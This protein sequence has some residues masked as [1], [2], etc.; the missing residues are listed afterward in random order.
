M[1]YGIIFIP[2]FVA[3]ARLAAAAT[4]TKQQ[5]VVVVVLLLLPLFLLVPSLCQL[6]NVIDKL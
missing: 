6:G 5:R 3:S 1:V 2:L 4:A